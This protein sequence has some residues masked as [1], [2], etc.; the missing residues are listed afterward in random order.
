[1]TDYA[2]ADARHALSVPRL[3]G[4]TRPACAGWQPPRQSGC[5]ASSTPTAPLLRVSTCHTA[6]QSA[7]ST[8]GP[9][10]RTPR[11]STRRPPKGTGCSRWAE[12][13]TRICS[14]ERGGRASRLATNRQISR[15]RPARAQ[16]ATSQR[17]AD[18]SSVQHWLG[19]RS[20]D[21]LG[22]PGEVVDQHRRIEDAIAL[23]E[24][25]EAEGDGFPRLHR[26]SRSQPAGRA[27][28]D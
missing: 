20:G 4:P 26:S 15:R 1:V 6:S 12:D 7:R 24:D 3:T 28:N 16:N 22:V 14:F 10:G 25:D 11:Q 27:T 13:S 8:S 18:R 17:M 21:R 23:I 9:Y 5:G 19:H 2:G